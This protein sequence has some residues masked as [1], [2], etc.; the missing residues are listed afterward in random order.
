MTAIIYLRSI[1]PAE[2]ETDSRKFLILDRLV[3]GY[4]KSQIF[5]PEQKKRMSLLWLVEGKPFGFGRTI[6]PKNLNVLLPFPPGISPDNRVLWGSRTDWQKNL[7]Q[8]SSTKTRAPR[9]RYNTSRVRVTA[10][11]VIGY[12]AYWNS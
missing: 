1:T 10:L 3:V 8:T 5:V 2:D 9:R 12:G 4:C 11:C 6:A 7:L